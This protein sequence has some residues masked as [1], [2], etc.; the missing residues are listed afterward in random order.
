MSPNW[1]DALGRDLDAALR[2]RAA[3]APDAAVFYCGRALERAATE[4]RRANDAST[5]NSTFANLV[6][7]RQLGLLAHPDEGM[8]HTLR[9]LSNDARHLLR[10][11]TDADAGVALAF[12]DRLLCW[13][14]RHEPLASGVQ[15]GVRAVDPVVAALHDPEPVSRLL[16]LWET[17]ALLFRT[18]PAAAALL[19]EHLDAANAFER[20]SAVLAEAFTRFGDDLRLLQLKGLVHRHLG[21]DAGAEVAL[22]HA[23]ELAPDDPE[24]HGILG[25]LHKERW[26]VALRAGATRRARGHAS[27]ALDHYRK[28]W[29]A[30]KGADTYPG[31]NTATLALILDD[32]ALASRTANTIIAGYEARPL[33]DGQARY[34][35][36]WDQVTLAEALLVRNSGDDARRAR[37]LLRSALRGVAAVKPRWA[38]A[39][40]AQMETLLRIQGY[41]GGAEAFLA[42]DVPGG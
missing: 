3:Q 13:V 42:D 22:R 8:L 34:A 12:S 35:D 5:A 33:L 20:A 28:G 39:T 6:R 7:L 16:A 38:S 1:I 30:G 14:S 41:E 27:R 23:L 18:T 15:L 11:L 40:L 25:G 4:L 17:D 9:R 31:I 2:V 32:R 24:T 26:R 10:P 29:K 19:V 37:R 36:Y 21:D